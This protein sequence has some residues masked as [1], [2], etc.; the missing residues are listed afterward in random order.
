[1]LNF[2]LCIVATFPIV[3]GTNES[4][5]NSPKNCPFCLEEF[6]DGFQKFENCRHGSCE[7]CL[8]KW[9]NHSTSDVIA[10]VGSLDCLKC[11]SCRTHLSESDLLPLTGEMIKK[12]TQNLQLKIIFDYAKRHGYQFLMDRIV[13]HFNRLPPSKQQQLQREIERMEHERHGQRSLTFKIRTEQTQDGYV[14]EVMMPSIFAAFTFSSTVPVSEE[15]LLNSAMRAFVS[16]VGRVLS[17]TEP[18]GTPVPSTPVVTREEETL[19]CLHRN[20][21]CENCGIGHD[22]GANL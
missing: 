4:S 5:T 15:E 1:M 8:L 20:G 14:Y 6:E 12:G 11:P 7:Q 17:T 9:M 16:I 19:R 3:F 2:L 10:R 21:R 18:V 22:C 13:K